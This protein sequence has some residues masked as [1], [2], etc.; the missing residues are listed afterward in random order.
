MA[1]KPLPAPVALPTT[2]E[3]SECLY[4]AA[5]LKQAEAA[6]AAMDSYSR[7]LSQK[8]GLGDGDTVTPDGQIARK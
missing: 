7:Y 3:P 6:Q 2:L 8:Y 4:L 5:V 1:K